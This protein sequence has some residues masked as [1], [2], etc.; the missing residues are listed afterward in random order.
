MRRSDMS[1]HDAT[2][3]IFSAQMVSATC[4][5]IGPGALPSPSLLRPSRGSAGG[6]DGSARRLATAKQYC[7]PRRTNFPL[8]DKTTL[9]A[10][11]AT[12]QL[13]VATPASLRPSLIKD[14]MANGQTV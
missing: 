11:T 2:M 10:A 9:L 13:A 5:T 8:P 4:N 7:V 3:F 14:R 6:G 12:G 1:P